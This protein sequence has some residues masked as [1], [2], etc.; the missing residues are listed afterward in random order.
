MR[1]PASNIAAHKGALPHQGRGGAQVAGRLTATHK[2]RRRGRKPRLSCFCL[3]IH[4]MT[5]SNSSRGLGPAVTGGP[6]IR[7]KNA[8]MTSGILGK[9]APA[10]LADGVAVLLLALVASL[11]FATFR[12][13][14]LGWDD[15][16]HSE[17]GDLLLAFYTS[18]FTDRRA[19]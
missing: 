4:R 5:V 17:Y 6:A 8:A 19:F 14:G 15:Y 3:F 13:Y 2:Y 7:N 9:W 12:D 16:T 18:G 1:R 10:R 11:A